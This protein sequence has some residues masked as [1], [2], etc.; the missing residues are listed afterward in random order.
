MQG[1]CRRVK[2]LGL[3]NQGWGIEGLFL[4]SCTESRDSNIQEYLMRCRKE[5]V[6]KSSEDLK[7][8][9]SS[10]RV[11]FS[12]TFEESSGRLIPSMY[13]RGEIGWSE[14]FKEKSQNNEDRRIYRTC[15]VDKGRRTHPFGIQN[16]RGSLILIFWGHQIISRIRGLGVRSV[17][18]NP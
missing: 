1:V 10:G 12:K 17:A 16:Q 11:V 8:Q 14:F 5:C 9:G 15:K 4:Q 6:Q 13:S 18:K 7:S 2:T 3:I